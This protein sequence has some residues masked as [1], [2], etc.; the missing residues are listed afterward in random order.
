MIILEKY[1]S[2]MCLVDPTSLSFVWFEIRSGLQP[3]PEYSLGFLVYPDTGS[4]G[5]LVYPDTGSCGFG[6][7]VHSSWYLG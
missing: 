2:K 6:Y 5:F 3:N 7:T 1:N 4:C